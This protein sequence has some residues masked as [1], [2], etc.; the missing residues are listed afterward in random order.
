MFYEERGAQGLCSR[1]GLQ[2]LGLGSPGAAGA[3]EGA[4]PGCR[5]R[6]WGPEAETH[7]TPPE[8]PSLS[9]KPHGGPWRGGHQLPSVLLP[10]PLPV[11][12]TQ[13]GHCSEDG[14]SIL[15]SL[16]EAWAAAPSCPL[17]SGVCSDPRPPVRQ[18]ES[19]EPAQLSSV[20]W[21][22]SLRPREGKGLR[23]AAAA[24]CGAPR[25]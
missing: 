24:V 15:S 22:C 18:A 16:P 8:P 19:P 23:A 10:S 9:G 14:L 17:P 25:P 1:R 2:R 6:A 12:F 4:G 21:R 13:G 5:G 11:T 20:S 7:P 3:K